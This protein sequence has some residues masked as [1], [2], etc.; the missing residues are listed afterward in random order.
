VAAGIADKSY[1]T[2]K[3]TTLFSGDA[4]VS[5][6]YSGDGNTSY[7]IANGGDIGSVSQNGTINNTTQGMF[8]G[9]WNDAGTASLFSLC[10]FAEC[11][12]FPRT[13]STTERQTLETLLGEKYGITITH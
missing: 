3:T 1:D 7:V 9:A 6:I 10:E 8:L 12:Y 5:F 4:V 2:L 13:L 11:L